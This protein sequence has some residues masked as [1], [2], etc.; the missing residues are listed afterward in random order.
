MIRNFLRNFMIGRYGPDHLNVA[1]IVVSILLSLLHGILKL[2]PILYISCVLLALAVFRM[3]SRN[4]ARRR[5]ENDRFIRYWWPVRT[6]LSRFYSNIRYRKTH[7]FLKCVGCGNNLRVPK[8]KGKIQ[9]T[10]PKCGERFM[11]KT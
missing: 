8:G 6:R 11:K 5:A 7:R 4:I 9:I 3:L 1:M 10:C 2:A